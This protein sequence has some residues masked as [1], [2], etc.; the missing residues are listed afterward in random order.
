[1]LRID[2]VDGCHR[3]APDAVLA[4]R[5]RRSQKPKST[6]TA[7][8]RMNFKP[9]KDRL[10]SKTFWHLTHSNQR[11]GSGLSYDGKIIRQAFGIKPAFSSRLDHASPSPSPPCEQRCRYSPALKSP[12][13]RHLPH[14]TLSPRHGSW[15][16]GA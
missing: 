2:C 13:A 4:W 3:W 12:T 11:R 14:Q 15:G 10:M 8:A 16:R 6:A 1:M 7:Q 5:V 9:N